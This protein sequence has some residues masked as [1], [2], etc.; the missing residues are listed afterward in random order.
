MATLK[1]RLDL[2][3]EDEFDGLTFGEIEYAIMHHPKSLGYATDVKL[4]SVESFDP[5]DLQ[6]REYPE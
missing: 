4:I 5:A 6:V 2:T 1:I 3:F